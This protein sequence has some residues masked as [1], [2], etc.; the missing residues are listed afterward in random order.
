MYM[1]TAMYFQHFSGR[2][3]NSFNTINI[4]KNKNKFVSMITTLHLKKK[5]KF[6]GREGGTLGYSLT[7]RKYSTDDVL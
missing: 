6:W 1:R 5:K 7:P 2:G 4:H 3:Q